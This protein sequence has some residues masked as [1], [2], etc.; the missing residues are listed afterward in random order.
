MYPVSHRRG[1][2]FTLI[3]AMVAMA[4][5]AIALKVGVGMITNWHRN[6]KIE[7]ASEFYLEGFRMARAEAIK[8][9]SS[10]RITLVNSVVTNQFDY[11]IDICFSTSAVNCDYDSGVWSTTTTIATGDPEGTVNGYR[12]VLRTSGEIPRSEVLDQNVLPLG[13]SQVYY[14]PLGWVDTTYATHLTRLT[15]EPAAGSGLVF[16]TRA[17]AITLS[18]MATKCVPNLAAFDSRGCPP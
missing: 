6:A 12:S 17:I 10:S 15:L 7:S 18:G 11:Q 16:P 3:E 8:H 2:G 9:K 13:A 4:I 5:L 14:T 1:A